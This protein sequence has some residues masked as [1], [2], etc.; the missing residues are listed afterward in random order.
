MVSS[1]VVQGG[2]VIDS[3]TQVCSLVICQHDRTG[4]E[5]ATGPHTSQCSGLSQLQ[6]LNSFEEDNSIYLAS[7]RS[8]SRG[9]TARSAGIS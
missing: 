3:L 2:E 1:D 7:A 6:S 4:I 8:W 5:F 9:R